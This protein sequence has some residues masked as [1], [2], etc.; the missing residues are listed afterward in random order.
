M[1]ENATENST[2]ATYPAPPTPNPM[3]DGVNL[4]PAPAVGGLNVPLL[5]AVRNFIAT[6][7]TATALDDDEDIPEDADGQAWVQESWRCETGMCFAGWTVALSGAT[8]PYPA[9]DNT[10]VE[11]TQGYGTRAHAVALAPDGE[12]WDIASYASH[13][14]GMGGDGGFVAPLFR[15]GNT[16]LELIDEEID[17]LLEAEDDE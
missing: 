17:N 6:L 3:N 7:P 5:K 13:L 12:T 16:T 1:T 4:Y 9:D 10:Y 15:A 2:P 14:L 11:T 8:F